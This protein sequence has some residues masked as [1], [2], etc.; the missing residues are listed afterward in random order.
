M[1]AVPVRLTAVIAPALQIGLMLA[2][3]LG[4][5]R[6]RPSRWVGTLRAITRPREP[7]A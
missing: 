5:H 4:A 6:E 7:G 3:V 1:V 2:I